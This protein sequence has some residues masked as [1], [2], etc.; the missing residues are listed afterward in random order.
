MYLEKTR[1]KIAEILNAEIE[2]IIFTSGSSESTSIVF[3]NLS[4]RYKRG[5]VVISKVEHQ[6][7]IISANKLK[8]KGWD[9]YEWPVN[10]DGIINISEVDEVIKNNTNLVSIIWGQSEIGS[11][12]PVQLIGTKCK[13][14]DILFHIDGTQ[15]LSNG[16]FNWKELKCDLLSLSAHKFGGPKGIGLLLTNSKS[17]SFLKNKDIS[18][19]QEYQIRQGTT[20]LPLIAGMYQSIKNIKGRI[21]FSS[22]KTVFDLNKNEILKNYFISKINNIPNIK[23]TGSYTQRLPNHISFILFNSQR[24]PI[25]AYKVINYMSDNNVE[26][27]SGSACSSSS[28]KPSQI[29]ENMGYDSNQ[30]YS[31]I[32]VSLGS[33]NKKSDLDRLF[34]LIQNCI[35]KF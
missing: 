8:R 19:T 17:R 20:P 5:R 28:G 33:M 3:S 11:L 16:I 21:S 31:N 9:I 25:K 7:T 1:Q 35:K 34:E 22:D 4:D 14:L 12:Q 10:H 26:I 30:L 13:E 6:A 18:L 24:E 2:D 32:R 23:I 29:L 15:I 27:S